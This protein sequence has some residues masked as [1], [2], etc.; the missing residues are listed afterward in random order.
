MN[1]VHCRMN[2]EVYQIEF[3]GQFKTV[4]SMGWSSAVIGL[5]GA[6]IRPISWVVMPDHILVNGT[7]KVKAC[8]HLSLSCVGWCGG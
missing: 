8:P 1:N 4:K 5:F 2:P 3:D 6:R 7:Y